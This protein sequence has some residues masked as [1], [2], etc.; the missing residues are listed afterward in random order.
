MYQLRTTAGLGD[1]P[2]HLQVPKETCPDGCS[3]KLSGLGLAYLTALF[4]G[5]AGIGI[6]IF[7]KNR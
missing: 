7:W 6:T 5:I 1:T 3:P 2:W 4:V